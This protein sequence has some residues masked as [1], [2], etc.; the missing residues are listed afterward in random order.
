MTEN[1]KA[2]VNK[3]G[4]TDSVSIK[5]DE[6]GVSISFLGTAF[7]DIGSVDLKEASKELVKKITPLIVKQEDNF[8]VTIEGHTDNIPLNKGLVYRNNFELSSIRACRVLDSFIERGMNKNK[9]TA[10]G[11]G[12]ARPEFPNEDEQGKSIPENQAKNRRVVIKLSKNDPNT[13]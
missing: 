12:E 13:L 9:V 11:Y 5:T 6:S 7:F 4:L 1:I 2:E 8:H 3:L 10:V